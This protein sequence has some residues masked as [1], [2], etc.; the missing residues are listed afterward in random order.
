MILGLLTGCDARDESR[1][2]EPLTTELPPVQTLTILNDGALL[3]GT[4]EGLFYHPEAPA[5]EVWG[6]S[7]WD[8]RAVMQIPGPDLF[9]GTQTGLY[10]AV[11][12][13]KTWREAGS[14]Q[15]TA[16]TALVLNSAGHL[17]AGTASGDI[18]Q[19]TDTGYTWVPAAPIGLSD[20]SV[21][22]MWINSQNQVLFSSPGH[23]IFRSGNDCTEGVC[24]GWTYLTHIEANAF[25]SPATGIVLAGSSQGIHRSSD[26]GDTWEH[27]HA[28]IAVYAFLVLDS[29]R[30]VAGGTTGLRISHDEGTT[31]SEISTGE[32]SNEPHITALAV[33]GADFLIFGTADGTVVKSQIPASTL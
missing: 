27:V 28:G 29:H 8:V 31:W 19:S 24:T 23:G 9:V 6:D 11:P 32:S 14:A 25:C 5:W 3:V 16:V 20:I 12:P 13:Y 33:D 26:G 7:L 10:A 18:F 21:R 1:L 15:F 22:A 2:W 30:I 4:A 17:L